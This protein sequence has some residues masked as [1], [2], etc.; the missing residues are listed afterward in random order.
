M[1]G[2]PLTI[3]LPEG[4][5]KKLEKLSGKTGESISKLVQK[6]LEEFFSNEERKKKMREFLDR[7][8]GEKDKDLIEVWNAYQEK[9]RGKERVFDEGRA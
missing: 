3:Y 1:R 6:A 5:R 4:M 8:T 7:W 2:G 9:E